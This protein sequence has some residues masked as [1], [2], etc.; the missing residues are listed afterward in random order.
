MGARVKLGGTVGELFGE[1]PSRV[2]VS[3]APTQAESVR[4]MAAQFG[5]P[6]TEIGTVGGQTIAIEGVLDVSIGDLRERHAKALEP[7]VGS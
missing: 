3:F 7:I 2:V 1:D 5:V 6:L 4:R